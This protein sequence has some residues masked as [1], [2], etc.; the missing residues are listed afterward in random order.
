MVAAHRHIGLVGR[1]DE[2]AVLGRWLREAVTGTPRIVVVSGDPGMGKTMLLR[3]LLDEAR[4]VGA[5]SVWSA[6]IEGLEVPFLAAEQLL[7]GL[8]GLGGFDQ[9][10]LVAPHEDQA[11]GSPGSTVL[12]GAVE[13]VLRAAGRGPLVLVLDDL[14][15]ADE[16]TAAM[17]QHVAFLLGTSSTALPLLMVVAVRST[18]VG[19]GPRAGGRAAGRLLR[20]PAARALHVGPLDEV[21]V[22]ELCRSVSGEYP[23]GAELR[24]LLASTGGSPL[25]VRAHLAA[26]AALARGGRPQ[27]AAVDLLEGRLDTLPTPTRRAIET[28]AAVGVRLPLAALDV[29]LGA[30][31]Q[32]LLGPAV[33]SGVLIVEGDEIAFEHSLYR[34]AVLHSIDHD[35]RARLASRTA[36]S[37]AAEP[38]RSM[39]PVAVVATHLR[40]APGVA[41]PD[42]VA[43]IR[44]M[45]GDEAF[46]AGAWGQ[47]A[48]HYA[49]ALALATLAN[50]EGAEW[51]WPD[52]AA[53]SFRAG[54]AAFRDHD[55]RCTE[56]LRRAIEL[57]EHA[58]DMAIVA[59]ATT[60]LVRG[61]LTLGD[62]PRQVGDDEAR[63][64]A[65]AELSDPRL[66][67]WRAALY[68]VVAEC[69]FGAMDV[70]AGRSLAARARVAAAQSFDP[71]SVWAVELG[72]GLQ[73]LAALQMDGASECFARAIAAALEGPSSWHVASSHDRRALVRLML[74]DLSA[75]ADEA[76]T[77]IVAARSCHHW[78]ECSFGG[79]LRTS[80]LALRGD[81]TSEG[82]AE[83]AAAM[84]RR[85]G[86]V[87]SPAIL[88]PSLAYSRA[89]RGDIDGARD[90]LDDLERAG[91]R[92]GPHWRAL[93]RFEAML[94]GAADAGP[95]ARPPR[96]PTRSPPV[97]HTLSA[98]ASS[99]EVAVDEGDRT[100]LAAFARSIDEV[101]STGVV[102]A[103]DWP[104]FLPR[105]RAELSVALGEPDA[106]D[107]LDRAGEVAERESMTFE[108]VRIA[109][110]RSQVADTG[111]SA[112]EHAAFALRL[113]DG[114]GL[115][116]GVAASSRQ[117]HALGAE[118]ERPLARVVLNTDIVGS[119]DHTRRLGDVMWLEALDEHDALIRT[120]VRRFGGV[121]F[122]HTGDGM[123]AW[124]A[125]PPSAVRA[126]QV[127][128]AEFEGR[129][130]NGG[131]THLR[132]RAGLALGTPISRPDG[133]VFGMT[134]IEAARLCAE[135]E[136]GRGLAS[137][138]VAQL[139]EHVLASHGEV[140]LKGFESATLT[141]DV[142]PA[143]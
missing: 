110:L 26:Q 129:L 111:G 31:H 117:L 69:R 47:A 122:K 121:I 42:V 17:I 68:G 30:S 81:P 50:S 96:Q 7:A 34:H 52:L 114:A 48:D 131:R 19:D 54:E 75:A 94:I 10:E 101:L 108:R 65:L 141:F 86:Y 107:L 87:F 132:L 36:A 62:G 8:A 46:A 18:E 28:L 109:L 77:G 21:E 124:F 123:F 39:L 66:D 25:L 135:A 1:R 73:H 80:V 104:H 84:Y 78:A 118:F 27:A 127:L 58:S 136:P 29:L 38:L 44:W 130:F 67:R 120:I 89:T 61:L 43:T 33:E 9:D 15:W 4:N 55:L 99:A 20:E 13:R 70:D 100:L 3:W 51:A 126:T 88:F 12:V 133:D 72:E 64:L 53:R 95:G 16:A 49:A 32:A 71:A 106:R 97:L 83:V 90:A 79:A 112:A 59:P 98:L 2:R 14:Q 22:R 105:I 125:S 24:D 142:E 23:R 137:A 134:V 5:A 56:L 45:A 85:T 93:R 140:L 41:P 143:G 63:A 113:A 11:W 92:A 103:S 102:V 40:D 82:E 115:L 60:L 76:H 74:G 138:A 119:T 116:A 139:A 37:V 91:H 6:A 35:R 57:A 128:L